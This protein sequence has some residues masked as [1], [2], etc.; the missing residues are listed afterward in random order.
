MYMP[1]RKVSYKNTMTIDKK[2]NDNDDNRKVTMLIRVN[3]PYLLYIF[4]IIKIHDSSIHK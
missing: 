2:H 1:S 4:A 3:V